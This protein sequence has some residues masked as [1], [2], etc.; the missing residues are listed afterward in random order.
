[1]KNGM[2]IGAFKLCGGYNLIVKRTKAGHYFF[3]EYFK[4][5][6]VHSRYQRASGKFIAMHL[7]IKYSALKAKIEKST[8]RYELKVY[9]KHWAK[10]CFA[11]ARVAQ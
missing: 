4:G 3:N 11:F 8:R 5:K 10:I 9:A 6:K 2:Q 1:M 7:G